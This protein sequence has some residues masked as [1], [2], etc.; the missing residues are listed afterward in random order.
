MMMG[1]D[2]TRLLKALKAQGFVVTRT[3]RATGWSATV[4]VTS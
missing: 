1:N 4:T 2:M 3:G